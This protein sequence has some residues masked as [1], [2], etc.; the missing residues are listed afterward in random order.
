MRAADQAARCFS[1]KDAIYFPT[2]SVHVCVCVCV[3]GLS[4]YTDRA[5]T[6]LFG[7]KGDQHRAVE[8]KHNRACVYTYTCIVSACVFVRVP[9]Y[10]L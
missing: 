2:S 9:F 10:P 8:L 4:V 1:L 7:V 3:M 6:L 5:T